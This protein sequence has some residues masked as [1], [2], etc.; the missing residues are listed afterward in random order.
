MKIK[1]TYSAE[2]GAVAQGIAAV[3]KSYF[4]QCTVKQPDTDEKYKHIYVSVKTRSK[5]E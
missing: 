5:E 4:N 3:I 2:E 1:I